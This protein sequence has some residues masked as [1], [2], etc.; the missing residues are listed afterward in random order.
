MEGEDDVTRNVIDE[1][2]SSNVQR[3]Q[4]E[5]KSGVTPSIFDELLS[6]YIL[7]VHME[8]ESGVTRGIIDEFHSSDVQR[9]EMEGESGV[10]RSI[11]GEL[12]SWELQG[13]QM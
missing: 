2:H 8:G 10:T 13:D 6:W 5:E 3:D 11:T 12:H 7:G 9:D 1:R 4:M